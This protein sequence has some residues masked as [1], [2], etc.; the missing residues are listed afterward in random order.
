MLLVTFITF[1]LLQVG[2]DKLMYHFSLMQAVDGVK[3]H[4]RRYHEMQSMCYPNLSQPAKIYILII[5]LILG[6]FVPFSII[7]FSYVSI[8]CMIGKRVR[9]R[10]NTAL[11]ET[12]TTHFQPNASS[13]DY[14]PAGSIQLRENKTR[15]NSRT[16]SMSRRMSDFMRNILL[17]RPH[18]GLENRSYMTDSD[19]HSTPYNSSRKSTNPPQ[20]HRTDDSNYQGNMGAAH[21]Y[22]KP[23]TSEQ[24]SSEDDPLHDPQLEKAMRHGGNVRLRN[25]NS[26]IKYPVLYDTTNDNIPQ[27]IEEHP[28]EGEGEEEELLRASN[29]SSIIEGLSQQSVRTTPSIR[30]VQRNS[31]SRRESGGSYGSSMDS[32]ATDQTSLIPCIDKRYSGVT[33]TSALTPPTPIE[34]SN[35]Y[36]NQFFPAG[37]QHYRKTNQRKQPIENEQLENARVKDAADGHRETAGKNPSFC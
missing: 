6:F 22:S 10:M 4:F 32:M 28:H 21:Q 11:S 2:V 35:P 34:T 7:V 15:R 23:S 30:I 36:T 8:A 5:N 18:D 33:V 13:T 20:A 3:Q 25:E 12:S 27:T 29:G 14:Q 37:E 1:D 9:N 16:D 17:R 31:G 19:Q 24:G 26:R